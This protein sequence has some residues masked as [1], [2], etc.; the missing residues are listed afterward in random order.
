[1]SPGAV[2]LSVVPSPVDVVGGEG[3][4]GVSGSDFEQ[5]NT[6]TTIEKLQ[7]AYKNLCCMNC[8]CS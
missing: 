4:V 3:T 5:P 7:S 2:T 8:S 6:S 1:M